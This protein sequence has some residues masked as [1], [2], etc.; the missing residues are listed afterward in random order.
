MKPRYPALSDAF[1]DG[2]L[3]H[4]LRYLAPHE[5]RDLL[6]MAWEDHADASK[7]Q[8]ASPAHA[9]QNALR[10]HRQRNLTA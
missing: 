2:P 5:R 9:P 8:I 10:S 4:A 1:L 6:R 3:D 7:G